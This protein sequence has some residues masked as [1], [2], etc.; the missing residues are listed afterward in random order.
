MLTEA[1]AVGVVTPFLAWVA[2]RARPLNT[3]EKVGLWTVVG[4]TLVVD[5]VLL[6]R[7][8]TQRQQA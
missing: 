4:G 6:Y 3:T 8:W 1:L 2:T 5:G 7:W